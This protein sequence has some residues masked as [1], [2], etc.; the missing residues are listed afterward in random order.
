L[1]PLRLDLLGNPFGP[2]LRVL[3]ALA[4]RDD[5]HLPHEAEV[6]HLRARLA[7]MHAVPETWITPGFGIEDL[8]FASLRLAAG[9]AVMFP[10]TDTN[11]CRA[12]ALAGAE[13]VTCARANALALE[14]DPARFA[15]HRDAVALVMSPNDPSGAILIA[16]DAVRI[17]RACAVLV[18]DERHAAYSPRTLL[19]LVREFENIVVLRT[20]ETWAGLGGFP[21]AYA[22]A[23][24]KLAAALRERRFHTAIAASAVVAAHATLDDLSCVN[25]SVER[26]RAEKARLYRT[27][28]KLNMIQPFPS[29]ANFLLARIERGDPDMFVA[30]L[31]ARGISVHRP[32]FPELADCIRISALSLEA[33]TALKIAL[34]EIA[35]TL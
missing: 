35:A 7:A 30:E 3:D 10:P 29:W 15:V 24:P 20:F 32:T 25:A 6:E 18:V 2:S 22:I 23:P 26:I 11:Q 13:I 9:P 8:V 16:Q 17:A 1:T 19:P 14:V 21:I 31:C 5:L 33:T 28:R 4:S 27:L 34:I 12:A